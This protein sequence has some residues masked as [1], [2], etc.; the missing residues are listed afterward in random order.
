MSFMVSIYVKSVI[1]LFYLLRT[2]RSSSTSHRERISANQATTQAIVASWVA[3]G[4]AI[5][6][7][8]DLNTGSHSI[9]N[10]RCPGEWVVSCGRIDAEVA[11]GIPTCG[12]IR[13]SRASWYDDV[14]VGCCDI[15]GDSH[16]ERVAIHEGNELVACSSR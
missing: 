11:I 3:C 15:V 2:S 1:L 9:G 8:L 7:I 6:T 5:L 10:A 14:S 4:A 13:Q 16:S 12:N